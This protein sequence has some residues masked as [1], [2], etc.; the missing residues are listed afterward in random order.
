VNDTLVIV[1]AIHF[2]ATAATGG[3]LIF[4]AVVTEPTSRSAQAI[5]VGKQAVRAAA[6]G[7]AVAVA[8]GVI[9]LP[10]Q[11]A[12]ITDRPFEQVLAAELLSTVVAQ[13]QFGLVLQIRF[14]LAIIVAVCLAYDR[15]AILRRVG[16]LSALCLTATIAWSGHAGAGVGDLAILHLAADVLH[17]I[18]AAAW[19]G[20]LVSLVALLSMVDRGDH[21]WM[22]F[23]REATNRFSTLG[24]ASV[25]TLLLTGVIN[26]WI[27]V[28]SPRALIYTEY[29]RLLTLKIGL[30][31]I[32]VAFA[33]VNRL[34]LTPQIAPAS[35][36]A[37]ESEALRR[38]T[39]NSII[40]IALGFLIFAIVGALGT[41][42]PA[43]HLM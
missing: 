3:A 20:G 34:W 24:I 23:A 25:G 40:E 5:A 42:H 30:F 26:A 10:L 13:T 2:A 6:I 1:R 35:A 11:A 39:R 18:A 27:L 41:M 32:M 15:L 31:I 19:L 12:N 36:G 9:W 17:L 33:A 14:A 16:L 37:P 29:G 22:S 38:L 4:R 8:S 43:I 7:L 21:A 28:G